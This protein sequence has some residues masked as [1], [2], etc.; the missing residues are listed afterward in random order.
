MA[1]FPIII[2]NA[3]FD[4][5]NGIYHEDR[6]R[7]RAR[8]EKRFLHAGTDARTVDHVIDRAVNADAGDERKQSPDQKERDRRFDPAREPMREKIGDEDGKKRCPRG[9]KPL[10]VAKEECRPAHRRDRARRGNVFFRDIKDQRKAEH[11][12]RARKHPFDERPRVRRGKV[13]R[14]IQRI[15]D[16]KHVGERNARADAERHRGS[17][18]DRFQRAGAGGDIVPLQN[19]ADRARHGKPRNERHHRADDHILALNVKP[20]PQIRNKRL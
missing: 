5:E 15:G 16:R 17:D 18:H 2:P 8:D 7:D 6:E 9:G 10:P 14:K 3:R 13:K 1:F 19:V 12:D 20:E 11:G 4:L